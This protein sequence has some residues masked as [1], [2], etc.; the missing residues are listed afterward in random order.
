[1]ARDLL[2][3][4]VEIQYKHPFEGAFIYAKGTNDNSA[5]QARE[6]ED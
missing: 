2:R 1:M 4:R 6:P 5:D 3:A